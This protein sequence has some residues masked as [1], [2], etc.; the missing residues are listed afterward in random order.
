MGT[1]PACFDGGLSTGAELGLQGPLL[2]ATVLLR[3]DRSLLACRRPLANLMTVST[4]QLVSRFLARRD[5]HA[6]FA[7][8]TNS[9]CI[10][11][12]SVVVTYSSL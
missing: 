4:A 5:Q 3:L 9:G 6:K 12:C 11:V 8:P 10:H 1:A 7:L 2:P